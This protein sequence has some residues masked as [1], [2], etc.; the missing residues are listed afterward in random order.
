[1]YGSVT[2][3]GPRT[4]CQR[5]GWNEQEASRLKAI[6][7]H[8]FSNKRQFQRNDTSVLFLRT[9]ET[10][11]IR[12]SRSSTQ[13]IPTDDSFY[14]AICSL[15]DSQSS[16]RIAWR[17]DLSQER[18]FAFQVYSRPREKKLRAD[19]RAQRRRV[20]N[21]RRSGRSFRATELKVR[22][23]ASSPV[24]PSVFTIFPSTGGSP[25]P[26]PGFLFTGRRTP[27]F[28]RANSPRARS[29]EFQIDARAGG[30]SSGHQP[31]FHRVYASRPVCSFPSFFPFASPLH[32]PIASRQ[33]SF[34]DPTRFVR[35]TQ[36]LYI[37]EAIPRRLRATR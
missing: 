34:F 37:D 28:Q 36:L 32:R 27:G 20:W 4:S 2:R 1:M 16:R 5:K 35:I 18:Y 19:S 11:K 23:P 22:R 31:P 33:A 3:Y 10:L 24:R 7:Q 9:F 26:S 8:F 6:S 15:S 13:I 17:R 14:L 25:T 21:P 29:H 30:S 12:N